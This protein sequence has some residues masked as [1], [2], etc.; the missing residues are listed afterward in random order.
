[1]VDELGNEGRCVTRGG[2]TWAG[3]KWV[4]MGLGGAELDAGEI[5]GNIISRDLR[6]WIRWGGT[7]WV[8]GLLG[9][10]RHRLTGLARLGRV[11]QGRWKVGA[12]GSVDLLEDLGREMFADKVDE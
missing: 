6:R 12:G 8:S 10:G 5:L 7:G 11:G 2:R 1:V 9:L 3:E 4:W